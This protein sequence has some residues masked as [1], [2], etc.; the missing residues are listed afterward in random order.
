M[1]K[2]REQKQQ[3][4]DSYFRILRDYETNIF[5]NHSN[6]DVNTIINLKKE[7]YDDRVILTTVKNTLLSKAMIQLDNTNTT[8]LQGQLICISI[9]DNTPVLLKKCL[10]LINKTKSE[11]ENVTLDLNFGIYQ[12][13]IIN[14]VEIVELSETPDKA[15][16]ISMIL[17]LI[18][19]SISYVV[20]VLQ[21]PVVSYI[22]IIDKVKR[23]I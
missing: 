4:L 21:D 16:S 12:G 20:N 8:Q 19:Q 15:V 3:I 2:T 17:G 10:T 9:P 1:A 5:I 6:I 14:P 18:E 22:T 7:L 23:N 11:F 13:K